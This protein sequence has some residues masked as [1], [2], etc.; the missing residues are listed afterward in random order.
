MSDLETE[1][2]KAL[3]ERLETSFAKLDD[4]RLYDVFRDIFLYYLDKLWV[5]HIDEMQYLRDKV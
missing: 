5:S 4:N 2:T 1:L 3:T